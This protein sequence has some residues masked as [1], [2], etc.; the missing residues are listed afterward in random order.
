YYV[1]YTFT[2]QPDYPAELSRRLNITDGILRSLVT[3]AE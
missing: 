3:V 2:S 1:I